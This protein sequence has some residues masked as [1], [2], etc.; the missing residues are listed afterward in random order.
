MTAIEELRSQHES[1]LQDAEREANSPDGN[2]LHVLDHCKRA[3]RA[4]NETIRIM[5]EERCG[6]AEQLN[7]APVPA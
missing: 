2:P 3:I 4:Q 1:A 5:N 6:I 7:N